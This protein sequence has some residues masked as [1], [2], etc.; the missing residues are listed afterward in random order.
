MAKGFV[1][2]VAVMDWFSQRVLS[3]RVSIT[4]GSDFCVE[5]PLEAVDNYGRPEIFNTD[6]GVEFSSADFLAGLESP[7]PDQYGWQGK[8][9]GQHLYR[10]VVAEH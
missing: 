9:F 1:Y 5:A 10:A 7:G 4:I 2:L 8:I 6:Q 3:W